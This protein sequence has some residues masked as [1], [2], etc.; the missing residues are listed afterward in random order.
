MT[1]AIYRPTKFKSEKHV[2]SSSGRGKRE[3]K[4]LF[5]FVL[6]MSFSIFP[7]SLDE[8]VS[9]IL[10]KDNFSCCIS[11]L[12]MSNTG[13]YNLKRIFGGWKLLLA[14]TYFLLNLGLH[15]QTPSPLTHSAVYFQ[16]AS[17]MLNPETQRSCMWSLQHLTMKQY[18]WI[19]SPFYWLSSATLLNQKV[20]FTLMGQGIPW[21][22]Y[23]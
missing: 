20:I 5:W 23:S 2:K 21:L 19:L 14:S 4:N 18:Q 16:L 15:R 12:N 11:L 3:F 7:E 13:S 9:Y 10:N 22:H 6:K 8:T 17:Q 1:E